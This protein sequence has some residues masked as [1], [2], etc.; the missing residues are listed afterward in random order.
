MVFSDFVHQQGGL[1]SLMQDSHCSIHEAHV[2]LRTPCDQVLK[3]LDVEVGQT[4]V[5]STLISSC[6]DQALKA[7]HI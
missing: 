4:R 2:T 6:E 7:L 5:R 3:A 1:T